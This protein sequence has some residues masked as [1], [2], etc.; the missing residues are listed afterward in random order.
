MSITWNSVAGWMDDNLENVTYP[1]TGEDEIKANC[2]FCERR[3]KSPD[4]KQ[5]L[6]VNIVI[7]AVHCFRCDWHG[8]W[9]DM[10]AAIEGSY[11]QAMFKLSQK[12]RLSDFEAKFRELTG[13]YA[14]ELKFIAS[15]LELP[16][17]Y[18]PILS[19]QPDNLLQK[20]AINYLRK[21]KLPDWM[22][23]SGMFGTVKD[24]LRVYMLASFS[25]YQA[26]SLNKE[27]PKYLNPEH[28]VEDIFGLWDS[29]GIG[30]YVQMLDGTVSVVEGLFSGLAEIRKE[31]PA[32]ALLGK[33]AK[34][35][36]FRRLLDFP[37]PLTILMDH[38]AQGNG[39]EL[40]DKLYNAGKRDIQVGL[41]PYGDPDECLEYDVVKYSWKNY[42]KWKLSR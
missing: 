21:R 14:G 6:Q 3:G 27:E 10:V 13:G 31:R 16:D 37:R 24:V 41:L 40:A 23:V 35:L 38:D 7:R 19:L 33:V 25:Y 22:I 32:M 8:N 5:H 28:K 1:S 30:D 11:V 34:P 20:L 17:T 39:W 2:P 18:S 29:P 4:I 26:R 36:Q 42:M 9:I 12:P 15:R